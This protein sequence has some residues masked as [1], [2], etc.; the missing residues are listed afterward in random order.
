MSVTSDTPAGQVSS[1]VEL[2]GINV[3]AEDERKGAPSG[4]F[5]PWF[6]ANVSVL[7]ISYGAF[8]VGFGVSFWQA[9]I[10]AVVGIVLSFALCG[11]VAL[12]GKRGSAPTM[13]L[14][15]AAFGVKGNALPTFLS[16]VLLVGW[17]T[18]L[19]SLASL[20]TATVFEELG[21][22]GGD[23]TK[24]LGFLITAALVVFAGI[25]GFDV[26]MRLQT[27]IT[28]ATIF[29]TIG[30][31]ALT[32]D[33]VD[34]DTV[35]SAPSGS[36][37]AFIGALALVATG[38]GVGWANTA[39]DYSR[40]LPRSASGRGVFG[41]TT[42]GGAVAPVI[43]TVFGILLALS[44]SDLS[45]AIA[46]DPIGALTT[47]LPTWYLLPFI[48][49][50][51]LGLVGGAV[52]DIYSSGL[53]LLTLGVKVARPVAAA[54]DGVIMVIGAIYVVFIADDFIGPFMGF[55][56]TVGVPIAA[57]AG[58][59][60]ADLLLRHQPYADAELYDPRG[61]YGVVHWPAVLLV[62]VGTFV[63]WGLVTNTLAG[64]LDWQGYLLEPV[65]LGSKVDGAWAY[66]NLG[67]F[68]AF[69]VGFLGWLLLGRSTVARQEQ[70][71]VR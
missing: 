70:A 19:V 66:A 60:V 56:I 62:V 25:L 30:F 36:T 7:A 20:G 51:V 31:I 54:I 67:V 32:L 55:L 43:L 45:D 61:R 37:Q 40:Y 57:W 24:V 35:S 3:I 10:A 71:A 11:V 9:T 50:A 41:W 21:W 1:R 6:A 53:A 16:W 34:W 8:I 18:V 4:L 69:A 48:V 46:G 13:V 27:W 58:V 68:V 42:F 23:A 65:G 14:S 5:W 64:W 2:N 29:L 15:R 44:S 38:F 33:E 49:V 39:A 22:G 63:G 59:F 47:L 17:E 52:L 28:I 12:A 26:I